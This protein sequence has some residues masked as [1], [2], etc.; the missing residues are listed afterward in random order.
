[1]DRET[2]V[3]AG[4]SAVAVLLFVAAVTYVGLTYGGDELTS[5]GAVAVVVTIVGFILLMTVVGVVLDR[6]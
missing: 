3:E 1:M 6:R 2:V 4:I 5:T